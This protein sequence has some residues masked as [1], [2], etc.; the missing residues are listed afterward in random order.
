MGLII[1]NNEKARYELTTL[2]NS[3]ALLIPAE[4]LRKMTSALSENAINVFIILL[5]NWF[6]NN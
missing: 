3:I 5:N 1:E 2:D 6:R 4:T